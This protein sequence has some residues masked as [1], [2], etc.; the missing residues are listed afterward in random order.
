MPTLDIGGGGR[1]NIDDGLYT[2]S[3]QFT[4]IGKSNIKKATIISD[5]VK[6]KDV[7]YLPVGSMITA[8]YTL[9]TR[10]HQPM[11]TENEGVLS[12]H[13]YNQSIQIK[14]ENVFGMKYNENIYFS[15]KAKTHTGYPKIADISIINKV[16]D[17]KQDDVAYS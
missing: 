16:L 13:Y 1:G 12:V 15:L 2:I 5:A 6:D 14:M 3:L 9:N 17:V 7:F 10:T 11:R 4:N 8:Q